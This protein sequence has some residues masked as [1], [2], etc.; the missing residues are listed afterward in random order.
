MRGACAAAKAKQKNVPKVSDHEPATGKARRIFLDIS[1][2]RQPKDLKTVTKPNWL[3]MVDELTQMKFSAFYEKKS[4]MVE[5][6][7]VQLNKWKQADL[8]VQFIR[9]DNA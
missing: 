8:E 7:C 6:T 2:V 5:P 1:T 9:L 4:N 3:I